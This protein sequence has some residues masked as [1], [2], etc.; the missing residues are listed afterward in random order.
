[1]SR[2]P[3]ELLA[4]IK[5]EVP[6]EDLCREYAIGLSGSGKNLLIHGDRQLV[7]LILVK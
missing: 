2:L 6:L 7:E 4:R 1:M 5:R 3:D